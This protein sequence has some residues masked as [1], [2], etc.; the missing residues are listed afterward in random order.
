MRPLQ[1][2]SEG[3]RWGEP[4]GSGCGEETKGSRAAGGSWEGP[5]PKG[6]SLG[7]EK[8]RVSR[9]HLL[10]RAQASHPAESPELPEDGVWCCSSQKQGVLCLPAEEMPLFRGCRRGHVQLPESFFR[11]FLDEF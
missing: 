7:A 9:T 5:E 3:S 1:A 11:P 8:P 2:G 4:R 6:S 10:R